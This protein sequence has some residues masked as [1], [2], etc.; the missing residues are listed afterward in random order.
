MTHGPAGDTSDR[1]YTT[2]ELAAY[3]A[4]ATRSPTR[5]LRRPPPLPRWRSRSRWP[6][7]P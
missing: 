3:G 6:S 5:S 1:L 2:E 7:G 4:V